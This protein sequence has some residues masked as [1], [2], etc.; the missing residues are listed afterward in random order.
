MDHQ[1][2]TSIKSIDPNLPERERVVLE[3]VQ[4]AVIDVK[5]ISRE[6]VRKLKDYGWSDSEIV[7]IVDCAAF[8]IGESIFTD[9]L[10]ELVPDEQ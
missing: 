1:C 7:E 8:S 6:D 2:I 9:V 10:L 3:L 5:Q 4:Q